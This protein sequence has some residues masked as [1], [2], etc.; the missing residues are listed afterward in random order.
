MIQGYVPT[1]RKPNSWV[2]NITT[3]SQYNVLVST[4]M[5][6]V[7]F[8]DTPLTWEECLKILEEKGKESEEGLQGDKH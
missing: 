5:A 8:P 3:Q 2:G 6:W 4:G 1:G 7:L